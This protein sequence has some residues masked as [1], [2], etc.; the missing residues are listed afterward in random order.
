MIV[1]KDGRVGCTYTFLYMA[2]AR[3]RLHWVVCGRGAPVSRTLCDGNRAVAQWWNN[4]YTV[5]DRVNL[6]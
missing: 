6:S 5:L 2:L 4:H 1:E 3:C